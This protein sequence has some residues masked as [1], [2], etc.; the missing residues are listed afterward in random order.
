MTPEQGIPKRRGREPG[1]KCPGSISQYQPNIQNTVTVGDLVK[2]LV[3]KENLE[4]D[5]GLSNLDFDKNEGPF[6]LPPRN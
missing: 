5:G 3:E 6:D 1:S 2:G 4:R